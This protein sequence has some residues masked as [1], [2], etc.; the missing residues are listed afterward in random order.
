M[1][2]RPEECVVFEDSSSG[3]EAA[4]RGGFFC[5][6]ID[7]HDRLEAM[8]HANIIVKGLDE[9]SFEELVVVTDDF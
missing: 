7:R 9:V 3:V 6:G 2:L 1:G 5:V 4:F 8:G